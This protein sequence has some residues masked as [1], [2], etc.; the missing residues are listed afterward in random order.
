MSRIWVAIIRAR[1]CV[2]FV[3]L[4]HLQS[5]YINISNDVTP[6]SYAWEARAAMGE[7]K[8]VTP[9]ITPGRKVGVVVDKF[10]WLVSVDYCVVSTSRWICW[11]EVTLW[12]VLVM[13]S[14]SEPSQ[15]PKSY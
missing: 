6:T 2:T 7:R 13:S 11:Y 1:H 9:D 10:V 3:P 15:D 4:L 8:D 14:V 12:V 5:N